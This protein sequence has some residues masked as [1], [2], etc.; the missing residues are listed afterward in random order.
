MQT[1][2]AGSTLFLGGFV[3][4]MQKSQV[5]LL[6]PQGCTVC[7]H[8]QKDCLPSL[9]KSR[10]AC[11]EAQAASAPASHT[12]CNRPCAALPMLPQ[13]HRGCGEVQLCH[14]RAVQLHL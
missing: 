8:R 9:P 11:I 1:R 5:P 3:A 14:Q 6:L 7:V 13:D 12:P 4:C 10:N 2:G